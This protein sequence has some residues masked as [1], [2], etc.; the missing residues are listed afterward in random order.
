MFLI[1]HD[2]ATQFI[3]I[4]LWIMDEHDKLLYIQ[5]FAVSAAIGMVAHCVLVGGEKRQSL[6][7]QQQVNRS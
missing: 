1:Y 7:R 4:A 5:F 3:I 6:I 2:D